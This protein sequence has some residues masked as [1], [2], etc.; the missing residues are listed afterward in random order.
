MNISVLLLLLVN[1]VSGFCVGIDVYIPYRKYQVKL[2]SSSWFS[3]GKLYMPIKQNCLSLPRT[4]TLTTFG[5]LL[6]VFAA[7]VNMLYLLHSTQLE[8]LFSAS[9]KVKLF[10]EN[11]FLRTQICMIRDLFTY[12]SF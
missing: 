4:L 2:H 5:K 3:A 8:V 6:M 11:T 12:F 7:E 9:N 10:T 1:L